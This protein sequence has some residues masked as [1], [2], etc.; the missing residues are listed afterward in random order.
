MLHHQSQVRKTR[1]RESIMCY[2]LIN[3]FIV[4]T[5]LDGP[6][7]E[8]PLST[9]DIKIITTIAGTGLSIG[10][11]DNVVA[12]AAYLFR[13]NDMI[14][15]EVGNTYILDTGNSAV[16]F[17]TKSTGIMNM[18]AG[19][20]A[21]GYDGDNADAKLASFDNPGAFAIDITGNIYIADTDN[22]RIR[23]VTKSTGIITTVAGNGIDNS[24]GDGL[25]ATLASIHTPYGIAVDALGNLY[26]SEYNGYRIRLVTASTGI[27]TTIAGTGDSGYNGDN[28]L[29]TSANFE[30]PTGMCLDDLGNLYIA[31]FRGSRVRL[32]TMST[33]IITT[34]AGTGSQG[35]NGDDILAS[36]AQLVTPGGLTLD[37]F[38]NLYIADIF[39]N[40]IRLITKSTG[41]ITTIAGNG[42]SGYN[43]DDILPTSALLSN[44]SGVKV[45]QFGD[46]YIA[47]N[48]NSRI[49]KVTLQ[50]T[51]TSM[52]SAVPT[53]KP[54]ATPTSKPS[55]KPSRKPSA[56]PTSK[57][58]AK[59][60]F[61]PSAVPTSKPSA[62]P[63]FKPSAAPTSKPSNPK[64]NPT[65]PIKTC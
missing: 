17:V 27:I 2:F 54:S 41:I 13:P 47:D 29:A 55:A 57:P 34:V 22:N 11:S 9:N 42:T 35:Y 45:D 10:E 8:R 33:G 53:S 44:P 19:S 63:S 43:G 49:R 21:R 12:T 39:D 15:D 56:V 3:P 31:D 37:T 38:G 1:R 59:P 5:N 4:D 58:S 52:P 50:S 30:G 62:K 26:I 40:R 60:S 51:P 18:I 28:I 32:I 14:V 65:S 7:T 24:L 23:L 46:V 6:K 16:R 48:L 64:K 25:L 20:G 36:D 61:K